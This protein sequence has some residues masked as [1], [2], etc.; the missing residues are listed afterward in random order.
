[1]IQKVNLVFS[2][3]YSL[4][5]DRLLWSITLFY[6]ACFNCKLLFQFS[7]SLEICSLDVTVEFFCRCDDCLILLFSKFMVIAS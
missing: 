2:G 1:M 5:K 4:S 3:V 6:R 7:L